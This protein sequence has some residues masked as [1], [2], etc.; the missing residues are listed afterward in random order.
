MVTQGIV[1]I[2]K[3]ALSKTISADEGGF[4][5]LNYQNKRVHWG[6]RPLITQVRYRKQEKEGCLCFS[7]LVERHIF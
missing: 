7:K 5:Q 2:M 6:K 4:Y 1:E 3:I